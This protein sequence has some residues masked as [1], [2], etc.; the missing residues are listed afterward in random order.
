MK[1]VLR[2]EVENLGEADDVVKV[3][4]GY[5]RNFLVPKRLAVLATKKEISRAEKRR[6][7]KITLLEA[8]RGEFEALAKKLSALEIVITADA[9]EGGKLFGSVTTMDIAQ[10]VA[11]QAGV[12]IDKKKIELKEPIKTLGDH[13]ASLKIFSDI[14]A[15]LK[16]TVT[17][18]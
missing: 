13:A 15:E 6:A 10:A 3:A 12:E 1:I 5:G 7:E 4:D 2:K 18:K 16:I 8:R 17:A 11:S 14:V 9:G